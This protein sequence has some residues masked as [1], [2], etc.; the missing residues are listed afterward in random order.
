MLSRG[1]QNMILFN[2]FNK[3]S[4]KL[5]SLNILYMQTIH[6]KA[7]VLQR[8]RENNLTLNRDKCEFCKTEL[9]CSPRCRT[10]FHSVQNSSKSMPPL[11]KLTRKKEPWVWGNDQHGSFEKLKQCL[12]SA[13]IMSYYK[14][15]GWISCWSRGSSWAKTK[16]WYIYTNSV[17][18][19]YL[20]WC[21]KALR[22]VKLRARP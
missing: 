5:H 3:F 12:I 4:I 8:L 18:K 13:I 22:K 19:S 17:C 20:V 9:K 21:R 16:R 1:S 2:P 11:R 7:L 10:W 14:H 15:F 6:D